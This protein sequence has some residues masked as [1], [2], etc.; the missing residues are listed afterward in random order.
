MP[1]VERRLIIS[2]LI[3]VMCSPSRTTKAEIVSI[4]SCWRKSVRSFMM[5]RLRYVDF[6]IP[7]LGDVHPPA[8][9]VAGVLQD[10]AKILQ[11]CSNGRFLSDAYCSPGEAIRAF[12]FPPQEI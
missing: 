8:T 3:G 9:P 12:M 10:R 1:I 7:D 11:D 4:S 6:P 5:K 2:P